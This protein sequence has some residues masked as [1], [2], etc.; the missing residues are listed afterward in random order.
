MAANVTSSNPEA[1]STGLGTMAA[2]ILLPVLG[3]VLML[4]AWTGVA[5]LLGP[6]RLPSPLDL[7]PSVFTDLTSNKILEFQGGGSNGILPH[8]L[9]TIRQTLLGSA[10]GALL[11]VAIGLATGRFAW[12]RAFAQLPIGM[13]R[14]IP[15]LAAVPF[16]IL[17]FGPSPMAQIGVV[18][19]YA[20]LMMTVTTATAIA[21]LDPL[22]QQF[23]RT[24]GAS[25]N[26]IFRTVVLPAIVPEI[27][28]GLRVAV[29]LAWGIEVVSEL[30]GSPLGMGQ[31]F[32]R[33]VSFQELGVIIVGIFW[34]TVAAAITDGAIIAMSRTITRWVP[35]SND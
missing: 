21:N 23:A 3:L 9:Y 8:L 35:R 31:V 16:T 12:W 32:S 27:V 20:A 14:A 25:E 19:F 7:W 28:G 5:M 24:L 10:L 26:H 22:Q 4:A 18:V 29:G 1:G 33:M 13:L 17:W 15:P 34:V 2:R 6:R 30:A 11:G